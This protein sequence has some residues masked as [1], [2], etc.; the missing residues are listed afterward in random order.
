MIVH[1]A[2][3][4]DVVHS[5]EHYKQTTFCGRSKINRPVPP[6][7]TPTTCSDCVDA[8]R[9]SM[10]R[11]ADKELGFPEWPEWEYAVEEKEVA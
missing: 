3:I 1:R 11:Q 7:S 9:S 8:H 10:A 6:D 5:F 2:L 4:D